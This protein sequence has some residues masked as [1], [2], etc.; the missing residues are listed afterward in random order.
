M[1]KGTCVRI[2][3]VL[4]AF[5]FLLTSCA[6]GQTPSV[7]APDTPLYEW[8]KV[9]GK[10]ITV[11]GVGGELDRPYNAREFARY[12]ELTG[13]K[14]NAVGLS[15]EE[16]DEKVPAAFASDTAERPDILVGYG[17]TNVELLNPDE[18]FYD[19]SD[20]PWIG[21]LSDT[22]MNQAVYNRRIIGLPHGEASVSGILYNKEIFKKYNIEVPKT[23]AEFL[24][25]CEILLKNG[26]TPLYLPYQ[27]V[28]ML[29]FQFPLD[30]VLQNEKTLDGLN[31]GTLGYPD[32]PEM[33]VVLQWYKAMAEKGYFG[34]SYE[35]N[36][37]GGMDE[38]LKN[39]TSAMVICWDT[40]LYTGYS[41][42]ASKIGLMPAFMGVPE[43]GCFEG[44]N[45]LI[46]MANK[47]SPNL[48]ASLDFINYLA[49]PCNYNKAYAGIYTAPM[50]NHQVGSI[51]TPQYKEIEHMLK[52]R[53]GPFYN[54]T[55]WSRLRGFAQ[56]DA[57]YIQSYMSGESTAE[58][59][60]ADMEAARRKRAGMQRLG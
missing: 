27:D 48:E 20:A 5:S 31:D 15:V 43:G 34:E 54:S 19:F 16:F 6:G 58:K 10:T 52:E 47:K 38:G 35:Q 30:S 33:P 11:W 49:D 18:S 26:I 17:G 13:N 1:L 14:I 39:G 44:A 41:G 12:E 22:A 60:L 57:T 25:A 4:T 21:D 50:F 8:G 51:T 28:S 40:W 23:Q 55:T 36:D 37:W 32:I 29:M 7:T 46:F 3:S 59:C 24:A 42:D 56:I 2:I 53:D 9:T 45:V